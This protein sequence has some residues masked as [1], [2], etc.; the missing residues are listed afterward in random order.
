MERD[1]TTEIVVQFSVGNFLLVLGLNDPSLLL[2][3]TSHAQPIRTHPIVPLTV[4]H[5]FH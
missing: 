3:C 2:L 4:L 5:S 1:N